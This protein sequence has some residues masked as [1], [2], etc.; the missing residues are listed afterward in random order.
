[1][2]TLIQQEIPRMRIYRVPNRDQGSTPGMRTERY[3]PH[4]T[5]L[6]LGPNLFSDSCYTWIWQWNST[7][8]TAWKDRVTAP[9]KDK[10]YPRHQNQG[11][12]CAFPL[13]PD[14]S[15]FAYNRRKSQWGR[16]NGCQHQDWLTTLL[17]LWSTLT[18]IRYHL[19]YPWKHWAYE[20]MHAFRVIFTNTDFPKQHRR[21]L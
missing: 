13:W 7:A 10:F 1:M 4:Y 2:A 18:T 16:W 12:W 17:T 6:P 8:L 20:S 5:N 3:L 14:E 15:G 21:S 9:C 11:S 19:L